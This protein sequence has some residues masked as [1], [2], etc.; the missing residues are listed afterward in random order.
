[1]LWSFVG[2]GHGKGLHGGT[3][4]TT[5]GFVERATQCSWGEVTKCQRG[6]DILA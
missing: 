6:Q 4:A 5:K 1:M 3:R 2:S